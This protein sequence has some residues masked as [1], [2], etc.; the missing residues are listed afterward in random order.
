ME[1]CLPRDAGLKV[2]KGDYVLFVDSDDWIEKNCIQELYQDIQRNSSDVSCCLAQYISAMGTI[3]RGR[4]SFGINSL[5]GDEILPNALLVKTF[6]TSA[7]GKL[8][9]RDFLHENGLL[10]KEGIVNEDTLFSIQIACLA[11][12][13]S[14]VDKVLFDIREREGSI[15]RSS[16]EK[17]KFEA[18]LAKIPQQAAGLPEERFQAAVGRPVPGMDGR[19]LG[20]QI[21]LAGGAHLLGQV[22]IL[23]IHEVMLIKAAHGLELCR[24]HRREAAGAELDLHGG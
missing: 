23:H 10:F 11:K 16:F 8:Y 15:S 1:D 14:F 4:S 7:C 24:P 18:P 6:P 17:L 5:T 22:R 19:V 9:R 13:I 2:A 20:H 3:R 12:K 21:R